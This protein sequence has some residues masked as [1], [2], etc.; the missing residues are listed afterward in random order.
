MTSEKA[1][2]ILH[3]SKEGNVEVDELDLDDAKQLG[4]EALELNNLMR[5][6][7]HAPQLL[8]LPSETKQ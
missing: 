2:E 6:T 4:I 3:L 1:I 7:Y 5:E 8:I